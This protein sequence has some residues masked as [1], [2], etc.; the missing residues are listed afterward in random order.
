LKLKNRDKNL[1]KHKEKKIVKDLVSDQVVVLRHLV[2]LVQVLVGLM[3][4][5][6]VKLISVKVNQH[7]QERLMI[8]K[9]LISSQRRR[10]MMVGILQA[11]DDKNN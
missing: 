9:R 11:R 3:V 8:I 6:R 2:L 1:D 10:A 4:N 7:L 5:K